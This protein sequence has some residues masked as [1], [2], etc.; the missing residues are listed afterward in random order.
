MQYWLKD[1][2]LGQWKRTDTP[3]ISPDIHRQLIFEKHTKMIQWGKEQYFQ[4]MALGQLDSHMQRDI[5]GRLPHT[6]HK[7]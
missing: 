2:H 4:Q 6:I 1:R 5:F 3:K 7:I